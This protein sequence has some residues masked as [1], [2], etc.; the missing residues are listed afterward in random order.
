MLLYQNSSG[1]W[2]AGST[3]GKDTYLYLTATHHK[4]GLDTTKYSQ[5]AERP[6]IL[7]EK[8]KFV[9]LLLKVSRQCKMSQLTGK[10]RI[11]DFSVCCFIKDI[12]GIQKVAICWVTHHLTKV[13]SNTHTH[14]HTHLPTSTLNDTT[15]KVMHFCAA[16]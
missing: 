14:T 4:P 5:H 7:N 11:S 1:I 15:M 8:V 6:N 3:Y 2:S 9:Q 10:I 12:A 13:T 16:S